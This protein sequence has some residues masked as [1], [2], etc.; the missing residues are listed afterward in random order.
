M[1][2]LKLY[3]ER[4][5]SPFISSPRH[6]ILLQH[7]N[8]DVIGMPLLLC[9]VMLYSSPRKKLGRRSLMVRWWAFSMWKEGRTTE[10]R[11]YAHF[12]HQNR[13]LIWWRLRFVAMIIPSLMT[14]IAVI[15]HRALFV[16][17]Y[18]VIDTYSW[19]YC[20]ERGS[21]TTRTLLQIILVNLK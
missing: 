1:I 21:S 3:C 20:I 9:S 15:S 6:F 12:N 2:E 19:W 16:C 11:H 13:L 14:V 5:S 10:G 7:V 8:V 17:N 4:H 18:V